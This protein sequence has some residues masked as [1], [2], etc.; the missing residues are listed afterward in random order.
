[1]MSYTTDTLQQILGELLEDEINHLTK[2]WGMGM[3]LHPNSAEQLI[4]Y[5]LS[6][7]HTI[8][9]V[10]YES[11]RRSSIKSTFER[12]ML[13]LDWQPWSVSSKGEL[14]YTF[15]WILKRMWYWSSQLTP[16]YLHLCCASPSFLGNNNDK[17]YQPKITVF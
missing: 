13:V 8:L 12:M 1:M 17:F 5:L 3:W 15:I 16:E 14:I 11:K 10:F 7:I 2:F 6:E 9:P 4:K